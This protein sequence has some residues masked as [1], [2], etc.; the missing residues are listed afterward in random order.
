MSMPI[1]LPNIHR[2][3]GFCAENAL[4][5]QPVKVLV[6][7]A[8]TSD[9]PIFHTYMEEVGR[10]LFG[11]A[12]LIQDA[13]LHFFAVY[14]V[15]DTADLYV[16][17]QVTT[18]AEVRAKRSV[19]AGDLVNLGDIADVR[20]VRFPSIPLAPTDGVLYVGK[21]GWKF[22][23]YFDLRTGPLDVDAMERELGGHYRRMT[24]EHVYRSIESG[25]QFDAMLA[26][27]W[28]PFVEIV[29]REYREIAKAYA[30][31]FNFDGRIQNVCAAF[32]RERLLRISERWWGTPVFSSKRRILEA[33]IEGF[34]AGTDAGNVQCIKTLLTEVEGILRAVYA[35]DTGKTEGV[36]TPTLTRHVRDREV[37]RSGDG[38]SLL[39]PDAFHRYLTEVVFPTFSV[40]QG[41]VTM[42]RNTAGHGVAPPEEY[43]RSRALQAILAIDQLWFYVAASDDPPAAQ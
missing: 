39:L 3:S 28:F 6:K 22:L 37:V 2:V 36:R 14:H 20:R 4:A 17:D 40:A 25:A 35:A 42:S 10:L 5:G 34:L 9:D 15:G 11:P 8:L 38:A 30:D 31:R 33:G 18:I 43:T 24:F 26:D 29:G 7:A 32:A 23:L 1:R 41:D 27:G 21:I 12:R 16:N 13:I 19:K